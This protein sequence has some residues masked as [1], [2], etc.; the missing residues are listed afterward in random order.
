MT[1]VDLKTWKNIV[2]RTAEETEELEKLKK[3]AE[4]LL[5]TPEFQKKLQEIGDE[6]V[7]SLL[8]IN[9]ES[10]K[11]SQEVGDEIIR[12]RLYFASRMRMN[13]AKGTR[14][15]LPEYFFNPDFDWGLGATDDM[16]QYFLEARR[17]HYAALQILLKKEKAPP[18][19]T[20]EPQPTKRPIHRNTELAGTLRKLRDDFKEKKKRCPD[21]RELQLLA[22]PES[23]LMVEKQSVSIQT[24]SKTQISV[25]VKD[26]KD[27]CKRVCKEDL[28]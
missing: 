12:F 26:L 22:S 7:M 18:E 1:L 21:W 17:R 14:V 11:T 9:P 20:Q 19:Q 25:K 8:S 5:R 27:A 13:D 2:E 16:E 24:V 6:R 4:R 10:K 28:A 3:E 23:K 15:I